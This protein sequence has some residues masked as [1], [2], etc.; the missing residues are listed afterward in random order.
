MCNEGE[1]L[2]ARLREKVQPQPHPNPTTTVS[3]EFWIFLQGNMCGV[4]I[5]TSSIISLKNNMYIME[6]NHNFKPEGAFPFW[7]MPNFCQPL[8]S[9]LFGLQDMCLYR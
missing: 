7:E 2:Y 9:V 4:G 3:L 8:K 6:N 5:A 1:K